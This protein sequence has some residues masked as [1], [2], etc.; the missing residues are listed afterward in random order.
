M[1]NLDAI[2]L[3]KE[4]FRKKDPENDAFSSEKINAAAERLG[5]NMSRVEA[6]IDSM[7]KSDVGH[8]G[9]N[10]F[11]TINPMMASKYVE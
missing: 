8:R 11:V 3:V 2:D 7:E 4:L 9:A 10:G 1:K 5:L 6:A